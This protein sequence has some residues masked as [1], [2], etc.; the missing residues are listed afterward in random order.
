MTLGQPRLNVPRVDLKTGQVDARAF[1]QFCQNVGLRLKAIEEA[2]AALPDET[3]QV[4]LQG[5]VNQ[6]DGLVTSRAGVLT[7]R[8][9]Q[10]GAG[11]TVT[12]GDGAK[13]P[14]TI[15]SP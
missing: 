14:P 12:N 3:L 8:V 9:L 4:Q 11:V 13:G 1:A 2:I 15:S 5:L 6:A 10:P 7:T